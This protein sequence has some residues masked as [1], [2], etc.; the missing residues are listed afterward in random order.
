[1][2]VI[3]ESITNFIVSNTSGEIS[4]PVTLL[5]F[6]AIIALYSI[7]VYY[8]YRLLARKN[9]L[10]LNLS[11]YNRYEHPVAV[12]IFAV[13]FYIM[14]YL[15]LLPIFTFF[16]FTILS[17]L[18]LIIAKDIALTN[19]LII[20]A[21]LVSAVRI[22]AHIKESLSRELAKLIPFTLLAIAITTEGFFEVAP[23]IARTL[24]IPAL[25]NQIPVYLI[26]I[27]S[28]ETVMRFIDL[29]KT[30]FEDKEE[31]SKKES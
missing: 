5:F 17:I 20:S 9:I 21:S 22:T 29:I 8:F 4:L 2:A 7:L 1:M 3:P 28:V 24:E 30:F 31:D 15:I 12:K 10:E 26:F 27:I 11:Q 23:L 19:I 14:E 13:L 6:T 18:T 16:W 25:L